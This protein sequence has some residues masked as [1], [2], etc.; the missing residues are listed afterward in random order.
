MINEA[1]IVVGLVLTIE[2]FIT[3]VFD[4]EYMATI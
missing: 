2:Y 4:N 1:Y 3:D